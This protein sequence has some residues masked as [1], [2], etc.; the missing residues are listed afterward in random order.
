MKKTSTYK[1]VI[2]ALFISIG[3]ILPF[4]TGQIPEIASKISP[5]HIPVLTAGFVLGA[6]YGL[7]IGFITPLMRALI[8]GMPVLF[9]NAVS[10]AFEL[11][12]YGFFTGSLYKALPKK[13]ISII[14]AL[15]VSMFLGRVVWG[16]ATL[17]LWNMQGNVFTFNIFITGAFIN[18]LP[19]II[20]HLAII[21]TF[22]IA[23]KHAK[24][25]E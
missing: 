7:F 23:L 16:V 25:M 5:M 21:P 13:N 18:A 11:A 1:L 17:I 8:F 22:V 19:A 14:I 6:P 3:L 10:M 20:I 15:I 12:A 2:S 4:I 9:P 24:V